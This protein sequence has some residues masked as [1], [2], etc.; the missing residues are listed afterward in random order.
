MRHWKHRVTIINAKT[1]C[2]LVNADV[3][4]ISNLFI[5]L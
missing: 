3:E 2:I 5:K 1:L 4:K